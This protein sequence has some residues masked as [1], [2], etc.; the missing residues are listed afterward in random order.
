MI[1]E[2]YVMLHTRELK[3][4]IH[5]LQPGMYPVIESESPSDTHQIILEGA[6]EKL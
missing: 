5:P 1:S 2:L 6:E 3:N 4:H